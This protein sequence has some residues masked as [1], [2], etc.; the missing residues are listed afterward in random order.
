M[1]KFATAA[2]ALCIGFSGLNVAEA[3]ASKPSTATAAKPAAA[4]PAAAKPAA[5]PAATKTTTTAFGTGV[6]RTVET[7][8]PN[9][10]THVSSG[11]DLYM[12][13]G[14]NAK[15]EEEIVVEGGDGRDGRRR[16]D[17]NLRNRQK[18]ERNLDAIYDDHSGALLDLL[19]GV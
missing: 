4:K 15:F 5:A 9:P 3:A 18:A 1:T 13:F 16:R 10:V 19:R 7:S 6:W 17:R 8:P 14:A 12:S 2:L 11:A